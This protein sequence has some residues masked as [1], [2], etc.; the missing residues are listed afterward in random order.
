MLDVLVPFSHQTAC[1]S[2]PYIT[3]S[4]C[5]RSR[6]HSPLHSMWLAMPV[7]WLTDCFL[8]L[9]S[10]CLPHC[11]L[12]SRQDRQPHT[13]S[14]PCAWASGQ[15]LTEHGAACPPHTVRVVC[16]NG[17]Q[18]C[19]SHLQRQPHLIPMASHSPHHLPFELAKCGGGEKGIKGR[20]GGTCMTGEG[21]YMKNIRIIH[22]CDFNSLYCAY[23]AMTLNNK[24]ADKIF[25]II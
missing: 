15:P 3:D 13:R 8:N 2:S 18:N 1:I 23:S 21:R 6:T 9:L 20:F 11:L 4:T 12:D 24:H 5:H 14:L 16:S 17:V 25:F 22:W 10:N 19:C 7:S